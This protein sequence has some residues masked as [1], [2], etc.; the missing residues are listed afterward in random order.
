M[1]KHHFTISERVAILVYRLLMEAGVVK[2][3]FKEMTASKIVFNRGKW[4]I[5]YWREIQNFFERTIVFETANLYPFGA[6]YVRVWLL[7]PEDKTQKKSWLVAEVTL[8]HND[9]TVEAV[10]F[11]P[12]DV[13]ALRDIKKAEE[14]LRQTK[15]KHEL[16]RLTAECPLSAEVEEDQASD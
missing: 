1:N 7:S 11:P 12:S 3:D 10:V 9:H 14:K 6:K 15:A 13:E 2:E 16:F 4:T 8:E 5:P